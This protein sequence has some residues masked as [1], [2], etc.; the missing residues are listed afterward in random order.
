M[1]REILNFEGSQRFDTC[2]GFNKYTAFLTMT[3][4]FDCDN[5]YTTISAKAHR[6]YT[7]FLHRVKKYSERWLQLCS[8]VTQ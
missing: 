7:G 4:C 6:F 2:L 1:K 5:I 3:R 8:D